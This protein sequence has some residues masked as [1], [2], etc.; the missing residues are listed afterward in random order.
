MIDRHRWAVSLCGLACIATACTAPEPPDDTGP[1][2]TGDRHGS[3][4]I[5][6]PYYPRAG[7]GGYDVED[8]AVTVRY[9]PERDRLTGDTTVTATATREL[10]RFNLDLRGFAVSSVEVGGEPADFTREGDAELV[11]T[12]ADPLA[13]GETIETRVRYDG[14]PI[15]ADAGQLG[16]NGWYRTDSGGA[17]VLGEPESASYWFPVNEHPRDKATFNLTASVPEGWTAVSIGTGGEPTTRD[18]WTTSTWTEPDPVASYL[19]VFAV[20]RFTVETGELPDGTP[21]RNAFAPGADDARD[22]AARVPE[23]VDF[24]SEHFG[25]YPASTAGGIYLDHATGFA[26]ETQGT[27]TYP[28]GPTTDLVVHEL[29]HQWYGNSVSVHSWADICLNECFAS[30]ATW[31]WAERQGADLDAFYRD[32]IESSRDNSAFWQAELYDMGAGNEFGAVYSK[33]PLALHALRLR[34]GDEAFA[35]VLREWPAEHAGGNAAWEEFERFTEKIAG[36][37]LDD[38]FS[39]WFRESGLPADEHLHPRPPGG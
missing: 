15:A 5:G 32:S 35:R 30:Y 17:F 10:T 38:F 1:V 31:L 25:D 27:P 8:Y 36:E 7:N 24:L 6:D 34:I 21:V 16:G 3:E 37:D 14:E 33:G 29:A 20:D 28:A 4:G 11:I 13:E 12:P 22:D 26:L 18:G 39:A 9:D 2:R 23:I 19:T